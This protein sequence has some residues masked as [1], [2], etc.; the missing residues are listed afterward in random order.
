MTLHVNP[1]RKFLD[2]SLP[3]WCVLLHGQVQ[4]HHKFKY[5]VFAFWLGTL[6]TVVSYLLLSVNTN[7]FS[8]VILKGHFQ[9][10]PL[11]LC[12]T[13]HSKETVLNIT[14]FATV[15]VSVFTKKNA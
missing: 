14:F 13:L 4:S 5:Q 1:M 6:N 8:F 11:S 12:V 7:Y 10:V 3:T 2:K 15:Q 9:R